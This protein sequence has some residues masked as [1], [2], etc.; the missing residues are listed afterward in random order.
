[1][2]PHTPRDAG[3][4]ADLL[5]AYVNRTLDR[6][7]MEQ[8]DRHLGSCA[9]CRTDLDDWRLV[10][11]LTLQ[12]T[13]PAILPAPFVMA[14]IWAA[15]EADSSAGARPSIRASAGH[16]LQVLIGQLPLIQRYLWPA[17]ALVMA[18]GF[19]I[20]AVNSRAHR[21]WLSSWWPQSSPLSG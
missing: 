18:L 17:S 1:M 2:M 7:T 19:V 11:R 6:E 14:R 21:A 8:V 15:V 3:H 10:A 4:V 9:A 20:A 16:A 13:S 12:V 5:P